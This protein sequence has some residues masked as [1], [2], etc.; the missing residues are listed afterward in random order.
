MS[1]PLRELSLS[2][3]T[4][5][6]TTQQK[7]NQNKSKQSSKPLTAATTKAGEAARRIPWKRSAK[8]F[9]SLRSKSG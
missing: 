3:T 4:T 8:A 6:T 9:L 5:A 1:T 7:Q 2:E